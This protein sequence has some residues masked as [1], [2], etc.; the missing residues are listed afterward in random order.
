MRYLRRRSGAIHI[1]VPFGCMAEITLPRSGKESFPVGAG[2]YDYHYIP[3][4]DFRT[5]YTL[6][7]RLSACTGDDAAKALK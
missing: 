6:E 3:S 4:E 7:T 5:C 2:S 1:E